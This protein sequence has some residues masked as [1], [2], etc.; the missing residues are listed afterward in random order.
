MT[1]RSGDERARDRL[2]VAVLALEWP[3]AGGH[4]GGVGRYARR[5]ATWMADRA[6]LTVITGSNP[7]PLEGVELVA[8]GSSGQSDRY[9]GTPIRAAQV[10]RDLAPD[11]VH[12]HGDDWAL[13]LV[14]RSRRP[15]IVRTYYGRS[16]AEADSGRM[17]HALNCRIQGLIESRCRSR[18]AR[19]AGIG[20]DSF[21]A[22]HCDTLIPPVFGE[23]I[24]CSAGDK[25]AAPSV[26]FVGEMDS[27]KRG[28]LALGAVE[29]ARTVVGDLRMRVVGPRCDED[30]YPPW[31]EFHCGLDDDVVR[32]LIAQSW[33]LLAPSS[34]EGFGI[35]A[36]EAM[37]VATPVLG[38]P[39]PGLNYVSG[40]G[41]Y[42][43]VVPPESLGA[44]LI[45][46]VESGAQRE[47][48]ASAGG[49]RAREIA[50][51]GRPDRYL[52]LLDQATT[53]T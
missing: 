15:P 19:A 39:N 18:Y 27:R 52:A 42:C 43:R 48:L 6:D 51:A 23:T 44:A 29:A 20:P 1:D 47:A 50:E 34:Y 16:L 22:F 37:T 11:V 32:C 40:H 14:P 9:Y 30:R 36:W 7:V 12:S 46:L 33:V 4:G 28:H 5:L 3:S 35:P 21:E 17:L 31:V 13:A 53:V 2:C 25:S 24:P 8:L 41:T 10:I 45:E 38:T 26:V 49:R